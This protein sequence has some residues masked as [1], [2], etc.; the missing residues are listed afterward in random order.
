MHKKHSP[1]Q[2]CLYLIGTIILLAG[3]AGAG[4]VY[5]SS[6]NDN[7]EAVGYVIAGGHVYALTTDESKGYLRN[8]ELYGGTTAVILDRFN[9]WLVGLGQGKWHAYLLAM[10]SIAVAFGF[11]FAANHLTNGATEDQDG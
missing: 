6:T 10:L 2:M 4:F 5:H 3:L 11:Y 9:R 7:S 1:L 8:M